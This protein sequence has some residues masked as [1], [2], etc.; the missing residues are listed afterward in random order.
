MVNRVSAQPLPGQIW[1]RGKRW[2]DSGKTE[3]T[4]PRLDLVEGNFSANSF[5]IDS[6]FHTTHTKVICNRASSSSS[7][8]AFFLL[9]FYLDSFLPSHVTPWDEEDVLLYKSYRCFIENSSK[10]IRISFVNRTR[11][12]QLD[13]TF[14]ISRQGSFV[15]ACFNVLTE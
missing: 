5:S 12:F 1:R 3:A 13:T 6:F 11:A 8:S 15:W 2:A 7:S 14:F 9:S 10:F 4:S